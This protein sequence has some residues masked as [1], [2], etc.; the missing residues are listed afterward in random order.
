[1][2]IGYENGELKCLLLQIG[3]KWLLP[4]GYIGIDESVDDAAKRILNERTHLSDPHLKFLAIFGDE[5]RKFGDEWKAYFIKKGL[6]WKEDYWTNKRFVTMTFYSLVDI[7]K[8]N[9][10]VG[11]IDERFAWVT[12]DELPEMW[13]DHREIAL[14]ARKKLK[15][16]IKSEL[17]TYNLLPDRFTMPDLHQLHQTILEEKLDRSRFQKNMIASGRFERLPKLQKE[18]PGRNPYQ[19]RLKKE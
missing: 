13:M 19:Y 16:D 17:V 12:F 10:Q 5:N 15:H 9:P 1:V 4:G 3:D 8:T 14:E 2:V 11:E 18:S 6:T 7:T